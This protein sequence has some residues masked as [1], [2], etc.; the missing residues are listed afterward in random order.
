MVRNKRRI[1][2]VLAVALA[3]GVAG[4]GTD[5]DRVDASMRR[6]ERAIAV[7]D[8]PAAIGAV[9]DVAA[10]LPESPESSYR[11]AQ[12]WIRAGEFNRAL[13]LLDAATGRFPDATDLRVKLAEVALQVGDANHALTA[14]ESVPEDA[15]QAASAVMLRARAQRDLGDGA[16]SLATLAAAEE[17]FPEWG[18]FRVSRIQSLVADQRIDEALALI[19]DAR[20]RDGLAAEK[21]VWLAISEASLLAHRQD[22][23]VALQILA[24]ITDEDPEQREAWGRRAKILVD[25]GRADEF[26]EVVRAALDGRPDIGFLYELLASAAMARGNGDEAEA[27]FRER[28]EVVADIASVELCV[29][30]LFDSG[31]TAEATELLEAKR[32]EFAVEESMELDYL[33]VVIQLEAGT[34]AAART[35][36]ED[37]RQLHGNDPRTEYLHARLDLVDGDAAAAADRLNRL[38]PRMNRSDVHHWYGVA[39]RTLGD[40]ESAEYRFGMA[41]KQ[42]PRQIASYVALISLLERRAAWQA[43]RDAARALLLWH[44]TSS[45]A[46]AALNR[47]LIHLGT[48]EEAEQILRAHAER[49][50]DFAEATVGLAS[51]LR[52]Q[53][54]PEEAIAVLDATVERF[55][56]MTSWRAERALSLERLGRHE[57]ALQ[58]LD[59]PNPEG[60]A[61][62]LHRVRAIVLFASGRGADGISEVERAVELEPD[63]PAPL[64]LLGD[65]H[66]QEGDFTAAAAA[67]RR[68]LAERPLDAVGHFRLGIALDRAGETAAA[69]TAYRRAVE[70]DIDLIAPRNNLA[71][72]LDAAGRRDEALA[73]AQ[74]AYARENSN[75]IVLDT[76]GWLYLR[77]QRPQRGMVL[78]ERAHALVPEDPSVAYHLAVALGETGRT[79]ESRVLLQELS[80]RL[81]PDHAL[82]APVAEAA[83]VLESSDAS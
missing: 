4:C 12:L 35:L 31:R 78:L 36:F 62:V 48:P 19:Q 83:A 29:R 55:G 27:L 50:P 13:W 11:I 18:D 76:L 58:E 70:I 40:L 3:C 60:P 65:Y 71:L 39:L 81:A 33:A 68:Y 77:S 67:Y 15:P 1:G 2:A 57:E 22:T 47:S 66:A 49:F 72:L 6:F 56:T 64:H 73:V 43:V 41:L 21:Q 7:N 63:E 26:Y 51:A 23:D 25:Q 5:E 16:A 20:A 75:P 82:Q 34:P 30:F 32:G 42:N 14:L 53:G 37:F 69:I 44:P 38:L 52:A 9:N 80:A 24:E 8:G 28:V 59:R 61:G 79:D 45:V 17:V 54:R 10:A 46:L 74:E